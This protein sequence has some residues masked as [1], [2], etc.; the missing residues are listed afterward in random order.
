M[1]HAVVSPFPPLLSHGAL[2]TPLP[3]L[4]FLHLSASFR[5]A[6]LHWR[7]GDTWTTAH[8]LE[9]EPPPM[10]PSLPYVTAVKPAPALVGA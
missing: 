9:V 6:R 5:A 2:P 8:E 1:C 4:F 3:L 10:D 7:V